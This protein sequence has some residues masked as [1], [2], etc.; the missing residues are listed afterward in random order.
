MRS[1]RLAFVATA[2]LGIIA[3][4]A[5]SIAEERDLAFTLGVQ[6]AEV[7][8][9]A[10]PG[11]TVCQGPVY[12]PADASAVTFEAAASGTPGPPIMVTVRGAGGQVLGSGVVPAGYSGRSN[13]RVAVG[14][15]AEGRTIT[16]CFRNEGRESVALYG[17]GPAAARTSGATLEAKQLGTD[18]TLVFERADSRSM[19]SAL[20]DIFQRAALWHNGWVG[21]WTFWVLLVLVVAGVPLLLARA[22]ENG[23]DGSYDSRP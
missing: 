2:A 11:Q 7:A 1:G 3:L 23:T 22:L 4:L 8:A 5:I 16:L 20:P 19:L 21:A 17:N 6:P 9:V 13:L 12:V 10:K 18:I 14:G 15:I